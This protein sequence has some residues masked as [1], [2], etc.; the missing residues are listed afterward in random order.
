VEIFLRVIVPRQANADV[1]VTDGSIT[2]GNLDGRVRAE[3]GTGK[4]FVRRVTGPVEA[5][6]MSGDV[7]ISRVLGDVQASVG[8]G[9]IRTGTIGGR[10]DLRNRSGDVELMLAYGPVQAH[11]TAGNV[12]VGFP[13]EVRDPAVLT[14]DGGSVRA[15][16]DGTANCEIVASARWGRVTS[17]LP[18][19]TREGRSGGRELR[20]K[21]NAGGP[22][23][24]LRADGGNVRI[25]PGETLFEIDQSVAQGPARAG[26]G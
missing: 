9:L 8:M 18:A 16:V 5:R 11:A 14:S 20:L 21:L 12:F 6:A 13:D 19:E 23:L 25:E 24:E 22:R 1:R 15:T 26:S 3:V 4:I 7:V 10:A 2:V 17:T